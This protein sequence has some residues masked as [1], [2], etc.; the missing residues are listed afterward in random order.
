MAEKPWL[1]CLPA[2]GEQ[3]TGA[4]MARAWRGLIGFF[5][6]WGGAGM[7]R[8]WRGH[9]SLGPKSSQPVRSGALCIIKY[10]ERSRTRQRTRVAR[11]RLQRRRRRQPQRRLEPDQTPVQSRHL[12]PGHASM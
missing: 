8:A 10:F 2:L 11:K 3:D 1:G 5:P 4:G 7:A 9:P 12:P 6:A